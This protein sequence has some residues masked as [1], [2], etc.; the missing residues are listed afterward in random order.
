ME[1]LA[2]VNPERVCACMEVR[3]CESKEVEIEKLKKKVRK[4]RLQQIIFLVFKVKEQK[5]KKKKNFVCTR[6]KDEGCY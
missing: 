4:P 1:C 2:V 3:C 5:K 6:K